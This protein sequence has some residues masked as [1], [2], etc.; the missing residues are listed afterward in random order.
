MSGG[1]RGVKRVVRWILQLPEVRTHRV[2]KGILS[3]STAACFLVL[4]ASSDGSEKNSDKW[5]VSKTHSGSVETEREK[6]FFLLI[7]VF[8]LTQ[9]FKKRLDSLKR[10][11]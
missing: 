5:P 10:F 8:Y 3:G 1:V 7:S 4:L 2:R 6:T 11:F 9:D